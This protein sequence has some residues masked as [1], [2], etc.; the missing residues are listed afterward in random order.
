MDRVMLEI[1]SDYLISS[2]GQTSTT[3]LSQLLE[4]KISHDRITRFL[5]QGQPLSKAVW[6]LAKPLVRRIEQE[7]GVI[8]I[9]DSIE[10]K[11]YSKENGLISWHYDHTVG[12][13]VKG[14]NFITAYYNV[15][16]PE[17]P[18]K[19]LGVPL[20]CE[21]IVKRDIW[22][23]KKQ[24]TESKSPITKNEYYRQLLR[25]VKA[26]GVKYSYVL[27][28]IWY[29]NVDNME[30]VKT[31]LKKHFVMAIKDNL[32]IVM[33][34]A[35]EIVTWKG[36]IQDLP[37]EE[38]QV[39]RVYVKAL[40]FPLYI[41]RHIFKN[42]NG[43]TGLLYLC[44]DDENLTADK[45]LMIYQKRWPIEEYHKS[46]KQNASLAKCPASRP[47]SQLKHIL[48]SLYGYIKLEWLKLT[49]HKNHFALRNSLYLAALKASQQQLQ[50]IRQRYLNSQSV[51]A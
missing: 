2:F 30:F 31:D 48:C 33:C 1:Y 50:E 39:C 14:L 20:G 15:E 25:S 29:T 19:C 3:V 21:V 37:F 49:T 9:D 42:E 28:D 36:K 22:N 17:N 44:T 45:T 13:S 26:N 16:N 40:D 51:I 34:D 6:Q 46:L 24:V 47:T 18:K 10:E 41:T 5:D 32:C 27:N 38:N 11:P 23:E 7:H 4:G 8:S 43:T 35:D 12:R